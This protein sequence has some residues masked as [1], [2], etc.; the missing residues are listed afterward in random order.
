M[1]SAAQ[2][3][4][5]QRLATDLKHIASLNPETFPDQ[6]AVLAEEVKKI[7][8]ASEERA[9]LRTEEAREQYD[10]LVRG[11]VIREREQKK[12]Q[13]AEIAR[14]HDTQQ[15]RDQRAEAEVARRFKVLTE[16]QQ[17]PENVWAMSPER[18][19]YLAQTADMAR[20]FLT[21]EQMAALDATMDP[22][23]QPGSPQTAAQLPEPQR[24]PNIKQHPETFPDG[25]LVQIKDNGDGTLEARLITGEVFRGDPLTVTRKIGE[26]NLNTKRWA[27][28]QRGQEPP[29]QP[30]QIQPTNPNSAVTFAPDGTREWISRRFLT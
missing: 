25:S 23:I 6:D 12:D 2:I 29:Q 9:R 3:A 20:P 27:R 26:A 4:H 7:T 1:A 22:F 17:G 30:E 15:T 8:D 5:E 28:G 13:Q 14:Y 11:N 10:N 19:R 16:S 21:P 18:L 24:A